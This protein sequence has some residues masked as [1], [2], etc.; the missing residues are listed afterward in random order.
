M[1]GTMI[2]AAAALLAAVLAC[3]QLNPASAPDGHGDRDGRWIVR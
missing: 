1:V 2:V 3:I